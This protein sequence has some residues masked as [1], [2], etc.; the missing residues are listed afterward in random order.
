MDALFEKSQRRLNSVDLTF[1]RSLYKKIRW[2]AR[3]IGIRGARGTGKTT[4]LLQYIK[5]NFEAKNQVL[6]A[7]LDTGTVSSKNVAIK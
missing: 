5:E 3:L 6:Y 1:I 7:S 2:D 4:L